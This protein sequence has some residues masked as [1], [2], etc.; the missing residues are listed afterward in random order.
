MR[1]TAWKWCETEHNVTYTIQ[2]DEVPWKFKKALH[3]AMKDWSKVSYGWHKESG[4]QIFV[5]KKEFQDLESWTR[6]AEA[7]PMQITEKRYWG[8]KERIILH[9][10]NKVKNA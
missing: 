3:E 4:H 5:F 9:G 2:F 8:D 7:F 6:W 1:T 10:K